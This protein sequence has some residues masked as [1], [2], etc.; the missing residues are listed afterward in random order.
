[1]VVCMQA[2][3]EGLANLKKWSYAGAGIIV[4]LWPYYSDSFEGGQMVQSSMQEIVL[5]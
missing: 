3:V 2:Y 4:F 5:Y 1:M